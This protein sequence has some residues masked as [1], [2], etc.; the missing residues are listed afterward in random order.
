MPRLRPLWLCTVALC[1]CIALRCAAAE[2]V[3]AYTEDFPPYNY[4]DASGKPTGLAVELL[5]ALMKEA[6]VDYRIEVLPWA[7]ALQTARYQPNSLLFT[8]ARTPER[9]SWFHW[10]G[11]IAKRRTVLMGLRGGPQPATLDDV[12][13]NR[14]GVVNGDAGMEFLQV[15]GFVAGVNLVPVSQ[16]NDLVRLL[17]GGEIAFVVANPAML[18][19]VAGRAG[20]DTALIENRLILVES[21]TGF[22]FALNRQSSPQLRQ[23]LTD[24]FERLRERGELAALHQHHDIE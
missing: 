14:V 6:G 1:C 2:A 15:H 16:R 18:R 19:A 24:A 9:E 7:R 21:P 12:R 22:Y 13:K 10:I 8:V 11:P 5:A 20:K 17:Y 23:R 3:V 4:V